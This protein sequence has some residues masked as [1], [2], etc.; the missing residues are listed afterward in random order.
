MN[1]R[2]L[3]RLGFYLAIAAPFIFLLYISWNKW[4]SLIIDTFEDC[5]V[6]Y[7]IFQGKVFY[8][9][10]LF[11]Y[12]FFPFYFIS[13][14]YKIFGVNIKCLIYTGIIITGVTYVMIYRISRFFLDRIFSYLCAL[15]FLSVFAFAF[16]LYSNIFN[17]I[18]PYTL[19]STFFTM[20]MV[21]ALY[22][23]IKFIKNGINKCLLGWVISIYFAFLCR[24][25]LSFAVWVIF[26][27]LALLY[28]AKEKLK[29]YPIALYLLSPLLLA[30]F[31]YWLFL[32]V[33]NAFDGFK[34]ATV[35]FF[36]AYM[37]KENQVYRLFSGTNQIFAN[38]K[39]DV[40][41][42]FYQLSAVFLLFLCSHWLSFNERGKKKIG[43]Y[44]IAGVAAF[45]IT[46]FLMKYMHYSYQYR[47]M[48]VFLILG[49]LFCSYNLLFS[50]KPETRKYFS[51]LTIYLLSLVLIL[52]IFLRVSANYYGF[53][54]AVPGLVCYCI[55]FVEICFSGFSKFFKTCAETKEYYR[56]SLLIFFVIFAF[57]C[58]RHS[59]LNYKEKKFI[60]VTERGT[61]ISFDD[62]ITRN[63][64]DVVSYLKNTPVGSSVAV[65]PQGVGLNFFSERDNPLKYFDFLP[66]GIHMI[67][68]KE[69]LKQ[70]IDFRIDYIVIV[71]RDTSE[72]GYASF[73]I[74]YAKDI[75]SWITANYRLVKVAG[76]Y[77]FRSRAFG[78]AIFEKI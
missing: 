21:I 12:G 1:L 32:F 20:F 59:Y 37:R 70:I 34:E 67:G 26:V 75:Y 7:K 44:F 41:T 17:F 60:S 42:F 35:S 66:L 76:N 28:A 36:N 2:L 43:K 10:V 5:W 11:P 68:E 61:V 78:F 38:L 40:R 52:R 15:T 45:L 62:E 64:W 71:S 39:I 4:G 27:L 53:F 54:M 22:F 51:L 72:F 19:A 63:F 48:P 14:L 65:F 74:D 77:P 56:F 16:Y 13:F 55:F 69:M 9:D 8:K 23:F 47:S 24:M 46:R 58:V 25:E 6:A 3:R 33:N 18:L 73:G 57:A 30:I 31:S 50:K 49:I 29:I